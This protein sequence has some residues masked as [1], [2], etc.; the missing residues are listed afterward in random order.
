MKG[1]KNIIEFLI[2]VFTRFVEIIKFLKKKECGSPN[3]TIRK[4]ED[5]SGS[6]QI[7][8]FFFDKNSGKFWINMF[9]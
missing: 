4:F 8:A 3:L 7:F 2:N 5:S 1:K 6:M 9:F